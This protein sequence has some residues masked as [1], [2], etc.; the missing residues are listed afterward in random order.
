MFAFL[1]G[2]YIIKENEKIIDD[3]RNDK[4]IYELKKD[5]IY[6]ITFSSKITIYFYDQS[7]FIKFDINR[8]PIIIY[9]E[10]T[11]IKKIYLRN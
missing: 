1:Q 11:R 5:R 8:P 4:N 10:F 9:P 2:I 3:K 7:Q 6:N